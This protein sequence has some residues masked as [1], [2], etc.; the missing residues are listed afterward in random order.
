MNAGFAVR[1]GRVAA[2]T[3][4]PLA[5]L[6]CIVLP[7]TREVYDPECRVLTRQITLEAAV[8]GGFQSC[9]GEGCA[10]M[11]SAMGVVT[12]ASVVVSGSIAL[13]GNVVYWFERQGRCNPAPPPDPPPGGLR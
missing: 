9:A 7:Q 13:V 12:A 10:A 3:F 5:L 1:A 11:L 2:A 6:G 4:L 8:L